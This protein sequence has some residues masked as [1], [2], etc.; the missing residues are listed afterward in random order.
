MDKK[1]EMTDKEQA[2]IDATPDDS[3]KTACFADSAEA[4]PVNEPSVFRDQTVQGMESSVNDREA[5]ESSKGD[6]SMTEASGSDGAMTDLSASNSMTFEPQDLP[7]ENAA[8][9]EEP[10]DTTE[11]QPIHATAKPFSDST[12]DSAYPSPYGQE[13]HPWQR[14]PDY[15]PTAYSPIEKKS[16]TP[17]GVKVFAMVLAVALLL[18]CGCTAGYLVGKKSGASGNRLF[19]ETTL[20]LADRPQDTDAYSTAQV[21]DLVNKS[22][23]GVKAYN[24]AGNGSM[25][26][27]I[28][29]TEDGYVITNDHIY[30]GIPGAKFKVTTYDGKVYDAAYVAGDTRSDL[31]VLK[32][33]SDGFYPATFGNSNELI[34]G[35]NV[36]VIGRPNGVLENSITRGIVSLPKRR[37]S[38]NTNYSMNLIQTD[39]PINPGNSGGAL[40]NMY[41]QVIGITSSKIIGEEVDGIG[42]AIP[43]AT[44]K[45][46]I[47]SLIQ[48]GC[49]NDRTKLGI[50][51]KMVDAV[52]AEVNNLPTTGV[53]IADIS[54]ESGL[55]GKVQK[56]DLITHVQGVPITT[57]GVILDA[58]E[59]CKPGDSLE[60]SVY[61]KGGSTTV[62]RAELLPDTGASSY[63]ASE[64]LIQ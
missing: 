34:T 43:T 50:T 6:A 15:Q 7:T 42:F 24:Q 36:V 19:S 57:D 64:S 55:N 29:Y 63:T 62:V 9:Q 40:V 11:A 17:K 48:Y 39:S 54:P 59:A 2:A 12:A 53:L 28:I 3:S 32:I 10:V 60:F 61:T 47:E 44:A 14:V 20:D 23:V 25:A 33:D 56:G 38:V 52:A 16:T 4:Q 35:E 27:G 45:S 13:P 31:A 21:Y 37:V 1:W 58:I 5:T 22:V 49:V 30:S 18:T 26:S 41:G 8:A 46:V 51:Y